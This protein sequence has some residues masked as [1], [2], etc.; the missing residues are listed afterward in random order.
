M[1]KISST[2]EDKIELDARTIFVSLFPGRL[3]RIRMENSISVG[4]IPIDMA[5]IYKIIKEAVRA[6]YERF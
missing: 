6:R 4:Y 5:E 1:F 3:E 2:D